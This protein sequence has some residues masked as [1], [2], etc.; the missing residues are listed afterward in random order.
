MNVEIPVFVIYAEVIMYLIL[1][2]LH[3]YTFNTGRIWAAGQN[4]LFTWE[5]TKDLW[6]FFI[7]WPEKQAKTYGCFWF[8]DLR[9]K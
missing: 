7:H 2:N 4:L 8:I 6:M 5:A 3:D 1:Y 9:R